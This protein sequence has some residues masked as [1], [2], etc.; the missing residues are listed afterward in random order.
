M[1]KEAAEAALNFFSQ[2][3]ANSQ[4]QSHYLGLEFQRR[5]CIRKKVSRQ[6]TRIASSCGEMLGQKQKILRH[7]TIGAQRN[8]NTKTGRICF[9]EYE[10]LSTPS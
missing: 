5:P 3:E 9:L 6:R 10:Q 2:Q 8:K 4:N 1:L 7:T